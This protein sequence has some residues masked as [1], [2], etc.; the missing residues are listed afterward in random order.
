M[1]QRFLKLMRTPETWELMSHD[2]SAF[3]L[4]TVIAYRAKRMGDLDVRGLQ[5]GQA[6]IGD[7]KEMGTT[8]QK[9]RSAKKR[10]EKYGLAT[11]TPTN[12]GTIAT[13]VDTRVYDINIESPNGQANDQA[14]DEQRT[15]NGQ[16][17]TIKKRK[18]VKKEKKYSPEDREM[19]ERIYQRLQDS[20][21][22]KLKAP[23]WDT[24]AEDIRKMR[25]IDKY[26]TQDIW[27]VFAWAN[28]DSFWAKN[29]LS[30]SKLR[31]QWEKL[32]M[33]M[34]EGHEALPTTRKVH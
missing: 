15:A 30:P 19:A 23:N 9:Y 27:E 26:S 4:L 32:V 10:L 21:P 22:R 17:T 20:A 12:K 34:D 11:F 24:W 2:P 7:H 13:I 31:A 28:Q 3:H 6:F 14:T 5:V 25:E 16:A 1:S 33:R 8:E 29:I 18:E